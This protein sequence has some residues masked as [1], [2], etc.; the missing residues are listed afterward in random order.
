MG[1]RVSIGRSVHQDLSDSS[2]KAGRKSI[3]K[4]YVEVLSCWYTLNFLRGFGAEVEHQHKRV[5][6]EE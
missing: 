6:S 2:I 5:R 3:V 1:C 4:H